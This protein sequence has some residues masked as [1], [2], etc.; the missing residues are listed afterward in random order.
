[1]IEWF[2]LEVKRD[3]SVVFQIVPKYCMSDSLVDS[4][5]YYISYEILAH[6]G[7]G[8]GHLNYIHPFWSIL[9]H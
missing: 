1:M 2:A 4:Q 7:R 8:N 6:S 9:V 3:H 5:G